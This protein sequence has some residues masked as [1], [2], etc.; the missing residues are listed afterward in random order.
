MTEYPLLSRPRP[1]ATVVVGA[2][3]GTDARWRDVPENVNKIDC[4]EARRL[5]ARR[6]RA[7]SV[8]RAAA[9]RAAKA[10]R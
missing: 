10:A 3:A 8:K 5:T 4:S 2:T 1:L 9:K 6:E 7:A